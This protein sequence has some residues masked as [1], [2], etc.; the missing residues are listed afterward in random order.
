MAKQKGIGPVTL[1]GTAAAVGCHP[2][3]SNAPVAFTETPWRPVSGPDREM[4]EPRYTYKWVFRCYTDQG[5]EQI[6]S[7]RDHTPAP[8]RCPICKNPMRLISYSQQPRFDRKPPADQ[9][10]G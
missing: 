6:T 4:D 5:D 9:T 3:D 7:D 10:N 1:L 8:P 2:A